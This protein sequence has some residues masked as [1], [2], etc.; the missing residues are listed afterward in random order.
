MER[1]WAPRALWCT[2]PSTSPFQRPSAIS[3]S[4]KGQSGTQTH[5][6]VGPR[7]GAEVSLR[8]VSSARPPNRTCASPRIRLSAS[9]CRSHGGEGLLRPGGGDAAAAVA[10]HRG[11]G[12]HEQ[13][14]ASDHDVPAPHEPAAELLPSNAVMSVSYTHLTLPTI[15]S[16]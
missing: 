6:R 4:I 15:Y 12:R 3:Q 16:V 13:G 7:R 1:Y 8:S 5:C 11:A 2:S 9:P 10:G 14:H